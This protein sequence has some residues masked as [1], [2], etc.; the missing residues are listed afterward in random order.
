[1]T[2]KERQLSREAAK[3]FVLT[4]PLVSDHLVKVRWQNEVIECQVCGFMNDFATVWGRTKGDKNSIGQM[5]EWEYSWETVANA[6]RNNV[7]LEV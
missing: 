3:Q 7:T 1:M 5:V 2:T 6:I 4:F